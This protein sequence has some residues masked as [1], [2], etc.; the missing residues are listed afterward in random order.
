[1]IDKPTKNR[2]FDR[3][4]GLLEGGHET[5][6]APPRPHRPQ[7]RLPPGLRR[8]RRAERRR[9]TASRWRKRLSVRS[10]GET[11][12]PRLPLLV[13]RRQDALRRRGLSLRG[14]RYRDR[15]GHEGRRHG[16]VLLRGTVDL[17]TAR[18]RR[19]R[20]LPRARAQGRLRVGELGMS[21]RTGSREESLSRSRTPRMR[22]APRAR[23]ARGPDLRG[24]RLPRHRNVRLLGRRRVPRLRSSPSRER[25][26]AVGLP[27]RRY[28][29][30][31]RPRLTPSE[32][33]VAAGR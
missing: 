5:G 22:D 19:R 9:S 6:L 16:H 11:A 14:A 30:E 3:A 29:L 18:R 4:R 1:M 31:R 28:R 25:C 26:A 7:H 32:I 13:S 23:A 33:P 21:A 27:R 2:H 17:H 15:G 8:C 20:R 10:G 24:V 12:A